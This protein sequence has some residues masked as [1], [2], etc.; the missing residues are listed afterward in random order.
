[1]YRE[2]FRSYNCVWRFQVRYA[3]VRDCYNS[4]TVKKCLIVFAILPR[5]EGGG[6]G[7]AGGIREG[8]PPPVRRHA[9][10]VCRSRRRSV[11]S[12]VLFAAQPTDSST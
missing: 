2:T 12:A 11:L 3:A 10:T 8:S 5:L 9:D 7:C 1:M 6:G 4:Q